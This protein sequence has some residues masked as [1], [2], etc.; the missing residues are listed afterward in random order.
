MFKKISKLLGSLGIVMVGAI[1][2]AWGGQE[3]RWLRRFVYP[4]ILSIYSLYIIHNWWVL[5][6]YT[7]SI[8]LSIGY[9]IPCF[10]GD[11]NPNNDKGSVLG[12]FWYKLF[13]N[14]ELWSNIFTRGTIGLGI[15]LSVISPPLITHKWLSYILMSIIIILI[16]SLNSWRGYGSIPVKLFGKTI[17]LLTV[18][19]V[20][21][22]V[23]T[24]AILGV[25]HG[26]FG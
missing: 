8:W 2:G 22:G 25:V 1:L 7:I 16:W 5:T 9:G 4:A 13:N 20:T 10:F 12:R 6:I 24:A 11:G 15:C 21:Y 18:D 26:V 17:N 3:K 23:T 14:N 19:L